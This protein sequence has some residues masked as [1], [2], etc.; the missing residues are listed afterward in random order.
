MYSRNKNPTEA[1]ESKI[2]Q[3]LGELKKTL[4]SEKEK[5]NILEKDIGEIKE[6]H[7]ICDK[8][9]PVNDIIIFKSS[10]TGVYFL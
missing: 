2:N 4:R 3:L 5:I 7:I 1:L 8:K 9:L 10:F 6:K